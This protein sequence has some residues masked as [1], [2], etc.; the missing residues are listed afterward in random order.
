MPA[1]STTPAWRLP[2]K[3]PG[4]T[5]TLLTIESLTERYTSRVYW[6][7]RGVPRARMALREHLTRHLTR[8]FSEVARS[9]RGRHK[10]RERRVGQ[11]EEGR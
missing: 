2:L 4:A 11:P 1:S 3:H 6:V 9:S 10:V 5:P 8:P 7:A